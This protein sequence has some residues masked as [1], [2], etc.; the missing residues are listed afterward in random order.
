MIRNHT[1][2]DLNFGKSVKSTIAYTY[3]GESR[4]IFINLNMYKNWAKEMENFLPYVISHE[5]IHNVLT[6]KINSKTS[7]NFD[8]IRKLK[9]ILIK[10][11][12]LTQKSLGV[13][14]V[15]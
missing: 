9:Q 3:E 14:L 6:R 15:F 13:W 7:E 1:V 2:S 11:K 5:V 8:N 4:N 12:I 10:R